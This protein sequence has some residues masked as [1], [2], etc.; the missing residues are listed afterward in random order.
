MPTNNSIISLEGLS[1]PINTLIEK[2]SNVIGVLYEPTKL[3]EKQK[4]KMM[5][6]KLKH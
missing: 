1:K 2:I 5:Q 3:E 4:L 6:K